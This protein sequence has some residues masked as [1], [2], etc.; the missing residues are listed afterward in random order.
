MRHL[1]DKAHLGRTHEHR[2]ALIGNMSASLFLHRRIV[3]TLA[4]AKYTRKYAERMITF[5]RV[6]DL[7]SRRH[8][9]RVLNDPNALKKLFDELG[10]HFKHRNGGYTRI[11]KLGLRSGDAAQMALLEL[12]GFDDV[13]ATPV[14]E[15]KKETKSRLKAS[16]KKTGSDAGAKKASKKTA[17]KTPVAESEKE[18]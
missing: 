9:A 14:E 5:A 8:V 4:K 1:N 7:S 12:V 3:T 17:A 11:I 10:P 16:Q 6:G 2:K 13:S 15:P 18:N